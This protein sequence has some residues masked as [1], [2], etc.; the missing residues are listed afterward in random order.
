MENRLQYSALAFAVSSLLGTSALAQENTDTKNPDVERIVVTAAARSQSVQ[1]SSVSVSSVSIESPVA[2]VAR[3]TA[4]IF[5]SIPGIRSESSGGE[6]NANIAVRGLPISSGGA[7]FLQIWEDGLPVLEFGDIAFGNADIFLRADNNVAYIEAI[8]GGSASTLASNSPGGVINFISKTGMEAGGSIALTS[9]LSYDSTRIDADYGGEIS[10][11]MYFH[12]GGFYRIGEGT[13][14]IGYDGQEGGQIKANLTKEFEN[15]YIRVYGKYLN[16]RA[17]GILPMPIAVS[18]TNGNPSYSSIANFDA[19]QDTVHS[20]HVRHYSVLNQANQAVN[21]DAQDGMHP[22]VKQF[23][24]ELSYDFSNDWNV[25]NRFKMAN[26][27]GSFRSLFPAQVGTAD[28]LVNSTA[29]YLLGGD[30]GA[31]LPEGANL[32]AMYATGPNAGQAVPANANGNGL[33]MRTH[34]FNTDLESLDNLMNDL[35]VSKEFQWN[36]A[37]VHFSA[38][39]Y[40]S[41]QDENTVWTWS[42]LLQD[43]VG[44]GQS[45]FVD[46]YN[47]GVKLT[48]NGTYAYGVPFWGNCCTRV[49]D[50]NT[51]ID[52]YYMTLGADFDSWNIDASIRYDDG[53]T[54]GYEVS[55][56]VAS[57]YDANGD[58]T[59]QTIENQVAI[60]DFDNKGRVDFDYDY[61][62]YSLGGNYQ[63]DDKWAM[64]ARYSKGSRANSG[65]LLFGKIAPDGSARNGDIINPVKQAELGLRYG[66][67]KYNFAVTLFDAKTE[68]LLSNSW[69]DFNAKLRHYDAQGIE[70]EGTY[71]LDNL[72]VKGGF[73]YTDAEISAN[74]SDPSLVGNQPRRQAEWMYSF[75]STYNAEDFALGLNL[76]GTTD[77]YAQDDNLLVMPGYT[78]VGLFGE[79]FISENLTV[80]LAVNNLFDKMGITESEE[81]AIA[82]NMTNYLRMRSIN[83]RTTSATIRYTF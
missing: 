1:E 28:E 13:R 48:E 82:E 51:K 60:F 15:G 76:V 71:S 32:T 45:A 27:S 40:H 2:K 22:V 78:T 53:N 79:Y 56:M 67:R 61:F 65:R 10:S 6:G 26:I 12:I 7:K 37:D 72:A 64:F 63:F 21:E 74:E 9:G 3:T 70:F 68:E 52:A 59:I 31:A 36:G 16:D 11:D 50:I 73:T 25:T 41:S 34:T 80:S 81:G 30:F 17:V 77:S 5:R 20:E 23:G 29:A 66:E 47:N 42:S 75:S 4:E 46:I 44:D 69:E 35:K 57:N 14:E 18:G 83:G 43:V 55:N 58:G 8:R 19:T 38:G 33:L 39:Y 49:Y 24:V 62:S 54:S